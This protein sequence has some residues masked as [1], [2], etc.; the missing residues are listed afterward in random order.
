VK[1]VVMAGGEGTRL[2]P[3][4][5]TQ[6]K[7][8]VP[9][10]GK[11]C[12]EHILDLLRR[13][14]IEDT[15]ITLA[16]LP[17]VIRSYLGDGED[18]GLHIDYA[19]EE[20]PLG[21]AGS[22]RNAAE[23]LDGTFL[24]ISGDAL[25]DVDLGALLAFHRERGAM[26]TLA[27]KSVPNPLGFGVVIAD[28]EGR[29]ERF[30][31]KPGWGQVFSDTINT[32]I[33]VIE[34][35]VLARIPE[36]GPYDFAREL[37]P[38]LLAEGLPLFAYRIPEGEYWHDIGT[39]EQL[40]QANRDALDGRVRLDLPGVCLRGNVWIGE[41]ASVVDLDRIVGPAAIGRFARIEGDVTVGP[42]TSVG[43]N[44][45][46][47]EG[48]EVVRSILDR[49]CYIGAGTRV[50]GAIVGRGA[51]V[52][53]HAQVLEGAVVGDE[54]RVG[55]EA[56]VHPGVLIEPFRSVE[57]G[58]VLREHVV[59]E[60]RGRDRLLGERGAI[61]VVNVDVTPEVAVRLGG[62]IGTVLRRGERVA[63]A[64]DGYAASRML[65]R[66]LMAGLQATGVE[67][68]DLHV[69]PPA[70][71]ADVVRAGGMAA[72]AHVAMAAY[73]DETTEITL[74][75]PPGTPLGGGLRG[76]IERLLER[77][78]IRRVGRDDVGPVREAGDRVTGYVES[79]IDSVD[80]GVMRESGLRVV[81]DGDRSPA[82]PILVRVLGALGVELVA[83]N[84]DPESGESSR[85]TPDIPAL[86]I[87]ARAQMAA[88][89]DQRGE[90]MTVVDDAG[91][92]FTDDE[93]LLVVLELLVQSGREGRVVVPITTSSAAETIVAGSGITL[94]RAPVS[95]TA[96][97]AMALSE[98]VALLAR[99]V[100][101]AMIWPRTL[102]TAD[103]V[104]TLVRF[105]EL[106]AL[107]GRPLSEIRRHLPD[108]A[109]IRL[110]LP[111]PWRAKGRAMRSLI[112][113]TRDR[114]TDATDGLRVLEDE[115]WVQVLPDAERP[116]IHLVAEGGDVDASRAL[117]ERFQDLLEDAIGGADE[118]PQP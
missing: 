24:V 20:V 85:E 57:P 42:Y 112:E 64:R 1:A 87:A 7:P 21:T 44:T 116:L 81:V 19:L 29:I 80:H 65:A 50:D 39:L 118:N 53:T 12:I 62:A 14:G 54:A 70:L 95:P 10:A 78:E 56:V 103:A 107:D 49:G 8:M 99:Q 26:V 75:E 72:A 34:P 108:S 66:A 15:V 31:E 93:S 94:V 35:E 91:V 113:G 114:T 37:F 32:G 117:L 96:L 36:E 84:A 115:G 2:R 67:V 13:H 110:D 40:I 33:Y 17:Q 46:V 73:D 104:A 77:Q 109:V 82:A 48:S 90:R 111:C 58:R 79:L 100:D 28:E 27:V 71:A 55:A 86:T 101:G 88:V 41:G 4:T 22:V 6:P 63:I 76:R 3:L 106:L 38:T 11:P 45:V 69:G 60:R 98:P 97:L 23:L 68:H 5:L 30:L 74:F 9:I 18:L 43:P 61:G 92:P 25:C 59:L 102:G 16:Y 83:L 51:D 89:F 105:L 47:K 52:H